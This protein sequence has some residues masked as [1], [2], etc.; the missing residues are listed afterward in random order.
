[1]KRAFT[2][3][4]LVVVL[5]VI[6]LTTHLAVREVSRV[7]DEKLVPAADRQLDDIREAALAFLS[8]TGRPVC[9][10]NGTLSELWERPANLPEYR[11]M[12]ASQSNLVK[13]V[14]SEIADD[15]VY[16]PSGWRGPYLRM[17]TG[18]LRLRDPWGNAIETE[19]DAKLERVSLTNGL[20]AATVSHYGPRGRASERKSV[21]LLP[22][23]YPSCTLTLWATGSSLSGDV[24]LAWYAPCEGM[25]TGGV[26][27]VSAFSQHKFEGLTPGSRIVTAT[28][29]GSSVPVIKLVEVLPGDNMMEIKIP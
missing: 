22:R 5:L 6:A 14:S 23:N 3:L 29:A 4:E 28:V 21:S 18:A 27:T 17:K 25:I 15:S 20:F 10:T 24:R 8:D 12:R 1:M 9:A 26:K 16:V 13:G 11:V 7:H 2:L 19:D